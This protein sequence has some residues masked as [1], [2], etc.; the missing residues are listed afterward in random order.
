MYSGQVTAQVFNHKLITL[1]AWVEFQ[2]NPNGICDG[3][4][5]HPGRFFCQY[6]DFPL[7]IIIPPI[8]HQHQGLGQQ[9]HI[10]AVLPRDIHEYMLCMCVYA[11]VREISYMYTYTQLYL[12]FICNLLILLQI[13]KQIKFAC[14]N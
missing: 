5:W 13:I 11:C 10:E 9:A 3:I 12:V 2:G 6:Y 7:S 14:T 8:L 1:G 4:K